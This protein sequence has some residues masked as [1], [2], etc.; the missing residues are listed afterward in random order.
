MILSS[1]IRQ[2]YLDFF[3]GKGHTIIGSAP[4]VPEH[5]PTVLFT[6]AGMHPLIPYLLGEPHPGGKRLANYQKC[7]RTGDIESVGD[8][9]HLTFFEMLG[10]WSL[11]DYFKKE[12][13]EWSYKFLT[14]PQWLG[15]SPDRLSVSVFAGD[16]DAPR[17]EE[18][19]ELWRSLGIPGERLY[20]Y[21]KNENWW[22]PA[23]A[24]GPCGPDT[25]MFFDTGI[26]RCGP[27]CQPS[28]SC[29]KYVEIWNDVFMQYNKKSDGLYQPLSQKNVDTGMGLERVTAVL[30]D[31]DEVYTTDLFNPIVQEINRRATRPG[32]TS[33]EIICDHIRAVTMMISDGVSPSNLDRGYVLRRLIRRAIRHGRKLGMPEYAFSDLAE[34]VIDI[35]KTYYSNLEPRRSEIKMEL[36]NEEEKF[37]KTLA[38]G[39]KQFAKLT[40]HLKPNSIMPGEHAFH[41]FD[42]YGFPLEIT[43]ELANE[44]GIVIDEEGFFGFYRQHQEQSRTG[45]QKK[46]KGGLADAS[47]ETIRGHTATHLLHEALRRILGPHVFQKGSNITPERLR[48]DFSHP[49]KMVPE[50]I[51]AVEDLVNEQVS[52]KLDVHYEIMTVEQA[53]AIGAIGLFDEKY[54]DR[55]KVYVIGDFSKEFCGGPH[56]NNTSE[57][58]HVRIT[59]E[60][61][62]SAGIRR[63]RAVVD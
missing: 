4:L 8:R 39:E 10:N 48:F 23:G 51:K 17:D 31:F 11:G 54:A 3:A 15:I 55:V 5:D 45:A 28:C 34:S 37:A 22:G 2:K 29:G 13:I 30:N 47:W 18:S 14:S 42:T 50:Q 16:A 26:A 58:G 9:W 20:Y 32:D 41:L 36:V 46:F 61:P 44:K 40:A 12:A 35:L 19:A 1:D 7:I 27:L 60:E 43:K 33:K 6:T 52:R 53:K 25:E 49:A 57:V 24:A 63:I 62:C 21:G 59:K 38:S 56:V